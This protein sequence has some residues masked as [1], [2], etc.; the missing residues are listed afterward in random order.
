MLTTRSRLHRLV[1]VHMCALPD[2]S[3]L[4]QASLGGGCGGLGRGGHL[5]KGRGINGGPW[6]GNE[7]SLGRKMD[8]SSRVLFTFGW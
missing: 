2:L 5:M 6:Y 7:L 3:A 8:R 4:F 1:F